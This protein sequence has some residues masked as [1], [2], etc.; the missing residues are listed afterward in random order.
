[1]VVPL[2]LY[3][4]GTLEANKVHLRYHGTLLQLLGLGIV[5]KGL[6][7]TCERFEKRGLWRRFKLWVGS[8]VRR[9]PP[10]V[11][12]AGHAASM[13]HST[14]GAY[15]SYALRADPTIQE[16]VDELQRLVKGLRDDLTRTHNATSDDIRT[17]NKRIEYETI[18]RTQDLG[19][20]K[21][22]LD[23]QI[24][25]GLD[26]NYIGWFLVLFWNPA[27][28][29]SRTRSPDGSYS[30]GKALVRLVVRADLASVVRH[31]K[32]HAA[33]T[34]HQMDLGL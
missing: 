11:I 25:G 10:P 5:A 17:L 13:G 1:M 29:A 14:S 23:D 34:S 28:R 27:I 6:I 21:K 26:E 15:S 4:H 8:L 24:A 32:R 18:E 33:A 7:E 19:A 22:R 16:Q 30:H 9:P 31:C 20:T 12:V 2:I 3:W